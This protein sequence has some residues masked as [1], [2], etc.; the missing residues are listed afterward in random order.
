MVLN[1]YR[2]NEHG[3]FESAGPHCPHCGSKCEIVHLKAPAVGHDVRKFTDMTVERLM[4]EFGLTDTPKQRDARDINSDIKRIR[5]NPNQPLPQASRMSLDMKQLAPELAES[6]RPANEALA[7]LQGGGRL[8]P[9]SKDAS[10][11]SGSRHRLPPI[12]MTITDKR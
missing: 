9:I 1:D 3:V 10:R 7:R 6:S 2:C 5:S 4:G 12:S 11:F 8:A